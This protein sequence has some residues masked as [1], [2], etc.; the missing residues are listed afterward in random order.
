MAEMAKAAAVVD[1]QEVYTSLLA[2]Q[3]DP[4]TAPTENL[5]GLLQNITDILPALFS[6]LPASLEEL[7][8]TV[9]ATAV[10]T[11]PGLSSELATK[12]IQ[13][14]G[15]NLSALTAYLLGAANTAWGRNLDIQ[16]TVSE[17]GHTLHLRP[18]PTIAV[19]ILGSQETGEKWSLLERPVGYPLPLHVS[20]RAERLTELA[21]RLVVQV[22]RPGLQRAE[23]RTVQIRYG[24]Q[25]ETAMTDENGRAT[26][27]PI[28]VG[29]LL[30]LDI[31]IADDI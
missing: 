18:G 30:E 1:P 23:G 15:R 27:A 6:R 14:I 17:R 12:I 28:P 2:G 8:E 10:K 29:A 5:F 4:S 11:T 31:L 16:T 24:S 13:A 25:A 3:V 19:P 22:D 20:V 9:V 26:F 21:C 7:D